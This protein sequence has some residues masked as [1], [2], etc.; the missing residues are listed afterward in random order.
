MA[1]PIW[2]KLDRNTGSGNG[3]VANSSNPHTGRVARKGT[4]QV[5]GVGATVPDV[6]EVTQSPK[7]E[8]VSLRQWFGNVCSQDCG[9]CDC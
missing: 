1:K 2:V 5:D 3:T 7:P 8:F 6:Y 9:D 4:L